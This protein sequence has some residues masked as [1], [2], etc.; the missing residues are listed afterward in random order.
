MD[1]LNIMHVC[2]SRENDES[3]IKN[4]KIYFIYFKGAR[5]STEKVLSVYFSGTGTSFGRF[6]LFQ[7]NSSIIE[8]YTR[9]R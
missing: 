2:A 5:K 8:D 7:F 6:L 9:N 4:K 1:I 3:S